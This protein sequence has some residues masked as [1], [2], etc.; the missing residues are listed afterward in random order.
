MSA[1][2][3][4]QEEQIVGVIMEILAGIFKIVNF[5]LPGDKNVR[6]YDLLVNMQ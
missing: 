6:C 2:T 3:D 4:F 5:R 1:D